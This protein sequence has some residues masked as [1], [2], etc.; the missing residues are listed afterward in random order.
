MLEK[1]EFVVRKEVAK[2][3]LPELEELNRGG[4]DVRSKI[5]RATTGLFSQTDGQIDIFFVKFD[6]V[7]SKESVFDLEFPSRFVFR[8]RHGSS[9]TYLAMFD[10][11]VIDTL[12]R[13]MFDGIQ[14]VLRSHIEN[15]VQLFA[16]LVERYGADGNAHFTDD[17]LANEVDVG[18]C[19]QIHDGIGTIFDGV[20]H[21]CNFAGG[22]AGK[23]GITEVRIVFGAQ[24]NA[25]ADGL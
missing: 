11:Y 4:N 8:R 10:N 14:K 3:Y 5:A 7:I 12:L 2:E 1:G 22:I 13:L 23:S 18:T 19:G 6:G 21:F 15:V 9:V 16:D 20:L 24:S 17:S 25:D